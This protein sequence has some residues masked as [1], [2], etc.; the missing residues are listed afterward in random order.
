[1][2]K[3]TSKA[4]DEFSGDLLVYFLEKEDAKISAETDGLI[5]RALHRAREHGDFTGAKDDTFL[6]Y[7]GLTSEDDIGGAKAVLFIGLGEQDD[8]PAVRKEQ[9]RLAAGL[10][11]KTGGNMKARELL[12]VLPKEY[13]LA[14]NEIAE[15]VTEGLLLGNYR[16][17][18]Y[19]TKEDIPEK[20]KVVGN[21]ILSDGG[22]SATAVRRGMNRGKILAEAVYACR[23]MSNQPANKWT[24]SEFAEFAKKI[25]KQYG[26]KCKVI[27]KPAMVKLGM[28]GIL[29]VNQ[30]SAQ[31]PKL[32]ILEY[33]TKK[34]NPTVMLVGKGL[35]FDSGGISLKPAA[36]MEDM[37]YDMC[38]GAAVITAMQAIAM[39]KPENVNVIGLVPATE[40]LSGS[41]AIKPGD[42][43]V[44]YG[45]KTSEVVNT[46]AEGRLILA[47]ALAYGVETYSPEA[48]V[49]L[50]TLTG[51]VIVGLGHHRT[52]L[53]AN[54][55][56][57]AERLLTAGNQVGEPEWRLPLGPEYRKQMD[58]KVADIK[59]TGTKGGGAI[60]AACYLQE[61]VG[62]TPWAHLDIAG[63]AW[64]FTEKSYVP[65]GPSGTGT[66]TLVELVREWKPLNRTEK[67]S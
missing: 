17:T 62:D 55:D 43:I 20:E 44:H 47:D 56:E 3:L 45:G 28:G 27:E 51:A 53:M 34:D 18:L 49:D 21:F 33:R 6:F 63:T 29:G 24:P 64:D 11:A 2:I 19:K 58:S 23:D 32:V 57:L 14:P 54:N 9:L 26:L 61:F 48:I 67:D 5:N 60:T 35:T 12:A 59:N 13:M 25:S 7:P 1:M 16:F 22:L 66:R 40:N 46:D 36:G 41:A 8:D 15:C 10:A 39:D 50:A 42:I 30:G 4:P 37:K 52:G 65:K 38:G 31:P